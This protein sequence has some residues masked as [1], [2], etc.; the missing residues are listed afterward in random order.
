[1]NVEQRRTVIEGPPSLSARP[2]PL[3]KSG[4]APCR[5][6]LVCTFGAWDERLEVW[7]FR[8]RQRGDD[9]GVFSVGGGDR[10]GARGAAAPDAAAISLKCLDLVEHRLSTAVENGRITGRWQVWRRAAVGAVVAGQGSSQDRAVD[11]VSAEDRPRAHDGPC[12]AVA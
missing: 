1:M 2:R 7:K 12:G 11:S 3:S 5:V 8:F 6:P 4:A 10:T 9:P